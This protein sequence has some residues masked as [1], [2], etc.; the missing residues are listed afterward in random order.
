MDGKLNDPA[1]GVRV[2]FG[3]RVGVRV[4]VKPN[5]GVI[6]GPTPGVFVGV[7]VAVGGRG[8]D[9]FFEPPVGGSAV[10]VSV[11]VLVG[12]KVRVGVDEGPTVGVFVLVGVT[13]GVLVGGFEPTVREPY[14]KSNGDPLQ[15]VDT[16]STLPPS[17]PRLR[18]A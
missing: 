1:A 17:V 13:D 11:G 14:D 10:V 12:V 4:A 16:H 5:V 6:E 15:I 8:V 3:G 7:R 9:V 18:L 2:A